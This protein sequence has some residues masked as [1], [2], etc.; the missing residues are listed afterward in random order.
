MAMQDRTDSF[1]MEGERG[2]TL[3][4]LM[5][6]MAMGLFIIAGITMMFLSYSRSSNAVSSRTERMGDLYLASQIMLADVRGAMKTSGSVA[7]PAD[8]ATRGVSLPSGYPTTFASGLP[9]WD[10]TTKTFTYQ[11]QDGNTGIFQY[12][13][14]SNDRVYWLRPDSTVSTFEEM[15]RDLDTSNGMTA[16]FAA[17]VWTVTLNSSYLDEEHKSKALTMSFKVWPRN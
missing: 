4:E 12:Q 8:L 13:R 11:D 16:S 5:I 7:Q 2:F 1:R 3:I 10:S 9:Y 14:T 6:S 17:E 15:I